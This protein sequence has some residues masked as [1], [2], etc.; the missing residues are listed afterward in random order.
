VTH[1]VVLDGAKQFSNRRNEPGATVLRETPCPKGEVQKEH[2]ARP[3]GRR[4]SR[5]RDHGGEAFRNGRT[6]FRHDRYV[7]CSLRVPRSGFRRRGRGGRETAQ[8]RV[9]DQPICENIGM[10][11]RARRGIRIRGSREVQKSPSPRTPMRASLAL[12]TVIAGGFSLAVLVGAPS[13]AEAK[14]PSPNSPAAASSS[15][16]VGSTGSLF[17]VMVERVRAQ[18]TALYPDA[19]LVEVDGSAPGGP[20]LKPHS[21]TKWTLFFNDGG[22]FPPQVIIAETTLTN[23]RA[24]LTV[25]TDDVY[26][27]GTELPTPPSIGLVQAQHLLARYGHVAPY[28]NVTYRQPNAAEPY[29]NPLFIYGYPNGTYL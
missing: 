18:V 20:T 13:V 21:L 6:L 15:S 11:P 26:V 28:T 7:V 10:T 23:P 3:G 2:P 19:V 25:K 29:P 4:G 9:T 12:V 27:G 22:Q 1:S 14:A 16:D 17:R 24:T 8:R 5:M